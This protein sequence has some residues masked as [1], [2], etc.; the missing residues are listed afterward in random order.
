MW[1]G[2]PK[3]NYMLGKER[4]PS[5]CSGFLWLRTAALSCRGRRELLVIKIS[6]CMFLFL[7]S[8]WRV[9]VSGSPKLMDTGKAGLS[10]CFTESNAFHHFLLLAISLSHI[11]L[12][13]LPSN[14]HLT[15]PL[16]K[17]IHLDSLIVKPDVLGPFPVVQ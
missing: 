10:N 12:G 17:M 7:P 14:A 4:F 3:I 9:Q 13:P 8:R 1:Q 6:D 11:D 2:V 16:L 5:V 15:A